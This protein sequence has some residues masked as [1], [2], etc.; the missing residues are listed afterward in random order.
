[1]RISREVFPFRKHYSRVSLSDQR[2]ATVEASCSLLPVFLLFSRSVVVVVVDAVVFKSSLE[3]TRRLNPPRCLEK[4]AADKNLSITFVQ[5]IDRSIDRAAPFVR[6]VE[7]FAVNGEMRRETKETANESTC[8]FSSLLIRAF[9]LLCSIGVRFVEFENSTENDRTERGSYAHV[10]AS[11][12]CQ[13]EEKKDG[14][15][16]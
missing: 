6:G 9:H 13:E 16:R 15:K 10:G 7:T 3:M 11:R 4:Q 5:S 8:C 2:P 12:R 1:M 14:G